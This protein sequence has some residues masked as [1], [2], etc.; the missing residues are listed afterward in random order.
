MLTQMITTQTL[1][2]THTHTHTSA[3]SLSH[4][5]G[6]DADEAEEV[7]MEEEMQLVLSERSVERVRFCFY[8][9]NF[10]FAFFFKFQCAA[11]MQDVVPNA[12]ER[13]RHLN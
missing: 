9:A 5:H 2:H 12:A 7:D 10:F 8:L 6:A 13:S 1:T 3:L 4:S 11:R